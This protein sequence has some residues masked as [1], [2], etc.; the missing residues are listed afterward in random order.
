MKRE[1]SSEKARKRRENRLEREKKRVGKS[2]N[3]TR[4]IS[5]EKGQ[6]G[7]KTRDRKGSEREEGREREVISVHTYL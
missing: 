2:G 4:T 7:D 3:E 1:M 6:N 5:S